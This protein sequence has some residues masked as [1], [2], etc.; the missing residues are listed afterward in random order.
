MSVIEETDAPVKGSKDITLA[1]STSELKSASKA[2]CDQ[3]IARWE[4]DDAGDE[5]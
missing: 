3:D 2:V 4:G 1:V 5:S